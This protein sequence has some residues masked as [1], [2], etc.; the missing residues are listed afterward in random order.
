MVV[1]G[2]MHGVKVRIATVTSV[3]TEVWVLSVCCTAVPL[4]CVQ[5]PH[6]SIA[7]ERCSVPHEHRGRAGHVSATGRKQ[8]VFAI[9][10]Q[11]SWRDVRPA[12]SVYTTGVDSCQSPVEQQRIREVEWSCFHVNRTARLLLVVLQPPAVTLQLALLLCELVKMNAVGL[13]RHT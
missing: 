3:S 8:V 13:A 10:R 2:T 6:S 11:P 12:N 4:V 9:A 1:V 5:S 7:P